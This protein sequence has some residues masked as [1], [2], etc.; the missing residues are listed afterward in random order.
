MVLGAQVAQHLAAVEVGAA[1][2]D[3]AV[4]QDR[5]GQPGPVA[6]EV[7]VRFLVQRAGPVVQVGD[8]DLVGDFCASAR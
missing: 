6:G 3:A 2:R 5:E 7:D 1:Q 8:V 4:P